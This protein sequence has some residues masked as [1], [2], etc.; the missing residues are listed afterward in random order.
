MANEL[1]LTL[2]MTY[3]KNGVAL[4]RSLAKTPTVTGTA[5]AHD[6]QSIGTSEE[7]LNV[8]EVALAGYAIFFNTD[9]TNYVE[10]GKAAATYSIKLKPGE[11]AVLRLDSWSAVY[12]KANTAAV[13]LEYFL[14]SE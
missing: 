3:A 14:F 11:F 10:I 4:N 13:D 7:T 2:K 1:S 6:I 12:A 9:A 8:G 5:I